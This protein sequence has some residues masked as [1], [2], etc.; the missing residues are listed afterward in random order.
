MKVVLL[1]VTSVDGFTT[2][3]KDPDI[4][5][6]TSKEDQR[7]FFKRIKSAKLI[8]MGSKTYNQSKH[9]MKHKKGKTRVIFTRT[10][11]KYKKE[12]VS[13]I[14]E[15]TNENPAAIAKRFE[16]AGVEEALLV[17]GSEINALFL[18]KKLISEAYITLEPI[19][20][21]NGKRLFAYTSENR[22]QLISAKKLNKNGTLLLHYKSS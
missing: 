8:F 13:G 18:E 5:K 3:E 19:I 1:A 4:Y 7:F 2:K 17:G 10:P 20:F 22:F 11:E 16:K 12:E 9:L 6:W 21:G 15:F 14:L